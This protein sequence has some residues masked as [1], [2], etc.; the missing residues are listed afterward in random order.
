MIKDKVADKILVR[1]DLSGEEKLLLLLIL[2]KQEKPTKSNPGQPYASLR[3]EDFE[4]LTGFSES[5]VSRTRRL[6]KQ[7]GLIDWKKS[8]GRVPSKYKV[9][10]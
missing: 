1:P 3:R 9:T 6:L 8:K 4:K 5:K 10:L 2:R 7:R